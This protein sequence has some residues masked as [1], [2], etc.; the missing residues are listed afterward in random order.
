[1]AGWL[2]CIEGGEER[3]VGYYAVWEPREAKA[4][5][6]IRTALRLA[7]A[8]EVEFVRRMSVDELLGAGAQPGRIARLRA[9]C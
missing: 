4:R 5:R 2:V 1:M 7:D 3:G 9:P 6:R 8:V